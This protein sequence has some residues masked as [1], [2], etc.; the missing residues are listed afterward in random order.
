V[1]V[2]VCAWVCALVTCASVCWWAGGACALPAAVRSPPHA[3]HSRALPSRGLPCVRVC[4]RALPVPPALSTG[5]A[6]GR[7]LQRHGQRHRH[8]RLLLHRVGGQP[9]G[10]RCARLW[11]C[12]RCRLRAPCR[13]CG[14]WWRATHRP[15]PALVTGAGSVFEATCVSAESLSVSHTPTHTSTRTHTRTHTHARTHARLS[16]DSSSR[17]C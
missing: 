7:P 12:R 10:D 8:A 1:C 3:R 5:A 9:G 14:A 2:C 16:Q 15:H 13:G 11:A 17:C 4:A 6:R